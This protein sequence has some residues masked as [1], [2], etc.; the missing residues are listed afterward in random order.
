MVC[1]WPGGV[2]LGGLVVETNENRTAVERFAQN[3][4]TFD[5]KNNVFSVLRVPP[6]FKGGCLRPGIRKIKFDTVIAYDGRRPNIF[7]RHRVFFS[8]VNP[9]FWRRRL[10]GRCRSIARCG[11]LNS[12][13]SRRCAISAQSTDHGGKYKNQ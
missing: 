6:H 10:N 13:G 1:R 2:T 9:L 8:A 7:L 5:L 3:L 11:L 12:V 4:S